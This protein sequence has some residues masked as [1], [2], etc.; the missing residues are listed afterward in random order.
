MKLAGTTHGSILVGHLNKDTL[1]HTFLPCPVLL[2]RI[3]IQ[4]QEIVIKVCQWINSH[5]IWQH[6]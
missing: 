4:H 5:V 2:S 3:L 6:L 1:S